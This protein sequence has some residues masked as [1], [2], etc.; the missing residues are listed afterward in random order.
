MYTQQLS[1]DIKT[2]ADRTE[3]VDEFGELMSSY[4]ASGQTQ[5]R[6]HLQYITAH[7]IVGLADTLERKSLDKKFNNYY[8]NQYIERLENL[9]NSKIK[10]KT[11][12]KYCDDYKVSCTCKKPSFYILYTDYVYTASPITC[13]TCNNS[14]PLYRLPIYYDYGYLPILSWE[15]N[16]IS[17]DR[18]Q[19]NCEVGERW[20]M[21]QMQEVTSQLSKQGLEICKRIEELTSIPTYYYLYNYKKS[22]D[23]GLS[24]PCPSCL[25]YWKL[26][27]QLHNFYDFK[28]DRCKL[29]S[30]ISKNS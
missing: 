28:C 30:T 25:G 6:E 9:C 20:A 10:F 11:V 22:K 7:K 24:K 4:R 13:G 23:G 29:L 19:M 14:V 8:V 2:T 15:T 27:E 3:L 21:R 18:L 16:Y 17:C 26:Q 5:G 1:I 12:G